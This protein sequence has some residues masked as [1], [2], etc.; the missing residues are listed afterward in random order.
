MTTTEPTNLNCDTV[1]PRDKRI[2][3]KN[4]G[5]KKED[6]NT[7]LGILIEKIKHKNI[8]I[9]EKIY[10]LIRQFFE[11]PKEYLEKIFNA[12][13]DKKVV[14]MSTFNKDAKLYDKYKATIYYDE[15]K[16]EVIFAFRVLEGECP[17]HFGCFEISR[18]K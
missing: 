18:L 12:L 9:D 5:G 13:R 7:R 6:V 1:F 10:N 2:T 3:R 17:A 14:Y 15:I 16:T 11:Q 4:P 8:T